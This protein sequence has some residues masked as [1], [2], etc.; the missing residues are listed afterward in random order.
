MSQ[1]KLNPAWILEL[2]MA[3]L[4]LILRALGGR[5]TGEAEIA[6]AK[7]LGNKLTLDR[8]KNTELELGKLKKAL[9]QGSHDSQEFGPVV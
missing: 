4:R 6:E 3:D 9:A 5:M 1:L 8:I 2:S 7:A